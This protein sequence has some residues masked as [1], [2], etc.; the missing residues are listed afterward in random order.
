MT[1]AGI[2]ADLGFPPDYMVMVGEP[3][4]PQDEEVVQGMDHP[5]AQH[6]PVPTEVH[7]LEW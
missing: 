6:L 5:K 2:L 4:E 1:G 3:G 7:F